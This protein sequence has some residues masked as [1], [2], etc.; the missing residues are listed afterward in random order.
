[1]EKENP[2]VGLN[3]P[4]T[5]KST[6]KPS[7]SARELI[8]SHLFTHPNT[9]KDS[10]D[11]PSVG[12][13]QKSNP[14]LPRKPNLRDMPSV[15]DA[16][17]SNA[18]LPQKPNLRLNEHSTAKSTAKPS[19]SARELIR[20]QLSTPPNTRKHFRNGS[21]V[22]NAQESNP[23]LP[24][25]PDSRLPQ[26]HPTRNGPCLACHKINHQLEE[27]RFM[28][29]DPGVFLNDEKVDKKYRNRLKNQLR[30]LWRD[31]KKDEALLQRIIKIASP[32][33][34]HLMESPVNPRP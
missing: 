5:A 9:R 25:K 15:G 7:R 17:K 20:S 12:N 21:S 13:A 28:L 18:R 3:E 14:R 2:G 27:C 29:G 34:R 11:R 16:R 26:E 24:Q 4:S 19:R 32:E 10:R 31:A 1:M 6:V 22:D 8:R 30:W 23:R 33:V